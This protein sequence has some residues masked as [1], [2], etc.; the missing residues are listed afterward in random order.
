MND[1]MGREA[2]AN[3][4][5][6]ISFGWHGVPIAFFVLGLLSVAML[7]GMN[8]INKRQ[9]E[10]AAL[11]DVIM[12]L[13][14]KTA[15]AHLWLEEALT[16]DVT[17][18]IVEARS[19]LAQALQ[20]SE[21]ILRGGKSDYGIPIPTPRSPDFWQ[22]AEKAAALLSQFRQI[23][24]RRYAYPKLGVIGSDLDEHFDQIFVELQA[25]VRALEIYRKW[26]WEGRFPAGS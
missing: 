5:R 24:E 10:N 16:E 21:T 2:R 26:R 25:T 3:D 8:E 4:R 1:D 22:Q 11:A 19:N 7:I 18:D 6:W 13:Q 14:V 9:R 15:L 20:L 17:S 23:A 12:E